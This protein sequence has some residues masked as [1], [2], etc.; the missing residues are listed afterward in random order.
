ML[1]FLDRVLNKGTD[2]VSTKDVNDFLDRVFKDQDVKRE[3]KA[4]EPEQKKDD[5]ATREKIKKV[6]DFITNILD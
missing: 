3:K 1:D 2:G 5:S 4:P 6:D